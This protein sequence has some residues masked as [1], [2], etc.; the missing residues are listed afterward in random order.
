MLGVCDR[1]AIEFV[2]P[3]LSVVNL[4]VQKSVVNCGYDLETVT[5][6]AR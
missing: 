4:K 6:H 3:T 1:K 5:F 2:R